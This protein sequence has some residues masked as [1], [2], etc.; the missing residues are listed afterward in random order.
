MQGT[1]RPAALVLYI[2]QGHGPFHIGCPYD[3]VALRIRVAMSRQD[4]TRQLVGLAIVLMVSGGFRGFSVFLLGSL[5]ASIR[6]I[7]V[8]KMYGLPRSPDLMISLAISPMGGCLTYLKDL[9]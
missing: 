9:T 2:I 5:R 7:F 3:K 4:K 8:I 1:C 6:G